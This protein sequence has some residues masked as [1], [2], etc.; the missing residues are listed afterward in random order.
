MLIQIE[1]R[2]QI[3][4]SFEAKSFKSA[5]ERASNDGVSLSGCCK[6]NA[7]SAQWGTL[8]IG[9]L[10]T[11]ANLVWMLFT[12]LEQKTRILNTK[13]EQPTGLYIDQI[14]GTLIAFAVI[15]AL[16]GILLI[17]SVIG[18][19][20]VL[21]KLAYPWIPITA[22]LNL[23]LFILQFLALEGK[24]NYWND[25]YEKIYTQPNDLDERIMATSK[26]IMT[27]LGLIFEAIWITTF[28]LFVW[29]FIKIDYK[30]STD[31]EQS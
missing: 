9:C 14:F 30:N 20:G 21:K 26:L 31:P 13:S 1:R 8:L 19:K 4:R 3:S 5:M 2:I 6:I 27:I 18:R 15:E 22:I 7:K 25:Y 28:S 29:T 16:L 17:I 24:I 10:G 23:T 12:I 11:L